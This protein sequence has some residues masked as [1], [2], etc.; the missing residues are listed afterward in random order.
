MDLL[1]KNIINVYK[2]IGITSNDLVQYVK[3]K[4]KVKKVGHAG[5]LD[6]MAEGVMIIGINDGTKKLSKLILDDKEYI[7]EISFGYSTTTYDLT[8]DILNKSDNI[9]VNIND[10]NNHIESLVNNGYEQEPPIYSSIKVNGKKLYDYA[11]K[12]EEVPLPKR[13]VKIYD[14][15]IISFDNNKLTIW[16]KVSKGFY[17]RSFA[18]DIG[19]FFKCFAHLSKLLR[20]A[21]GKFKLENS[22]KMSDITSIS[23][24]VKNIINIDEKINIDNLVIG[25]FDLI[26]KGHEKLLLSN[27]ASVLTFLNNPSKNKNFYSFD[28]R[29]KNLSKFNLKNIFFIDLKTSNLDKNDFIDLLK[30]KFKIS[31]ISV[32]SDFKF[33]K[34]REGNIIDLNKHFIVNVITNDNTSNSNLKKMMTSGEIKKLNSKLSSPVYVSGIVCHGK[35]LGRLIGFPTINIFYETNI[36][37][38]EGSYI[39]KTLYNQKRYESITFIKKYNSNTFLI[40]TFIDNFSGDLYGKFVEIELIDFI[41]DPIKIN[42]LDELKII[43]SNDLKLLKK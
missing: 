22:I 29:I 12:K 41:R 17:V 1:S 35:K 42:N 34:G 13:N 32:G 33:G 16:L 8:G 38:K 40:E 11:R 25:H 6:P 4:L 37:L 30:D 19:N 15:K 20:V 2:P 43:I 26:H 24:D 14:Y 27:N 18:N 23:N 39:T 9:S 36:D 28:Q 7:A 10:I 31:K 3:R 21:S 5:T